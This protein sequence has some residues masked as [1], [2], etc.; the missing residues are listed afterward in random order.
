MKGWKVQAG[1]YELA[2]YRS[3]T[4]D[5]APQ[6]MAEVSIE[7]P[8]PKKRGQKPFHVRVFREPIAGDAWET[9]R[10]VFREAGAEVSEAPRGD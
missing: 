2:G 10:E 1:L 6:P 5:V 9:L 7:K 8:A 4:G 3:R